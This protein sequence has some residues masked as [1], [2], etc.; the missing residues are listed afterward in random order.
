[1]I[2]K[3]LMA[4]MLLFAVIAGAWAQEAK[5]AK[6]EFSPASDN[7]KALSL[8][9]DLAKYGYANNSASSL[10]EAAKI[11]KEAGLKEGDAT[12]FNLKEEVSSEG[13]TSSTA[14][15]NV[16]VS[17]DADK[18]LADAKKLAAGDKNLLAM[19]DKVANTQTRSGSHDYYTRRI[20]ANARVTW[21]CKRSYGTYSRVYLSG[22][23]DTDLDVYVYDSYGNLITKDDDYGDDC[24][25]AWYCNRSQ[26]YTLAIKNRGGV[27]NNYEILFETE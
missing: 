6:G 24:Y 17:L 11:V 3:Y 14:K 16:E 9:S 4:V 20:N 2:R 5:E 15:K 1:M 19:A 22:D 18:L 23:G 25:V 7:A 13:V 10:I 8:A 21:D 26:T 27:Y 12:Q